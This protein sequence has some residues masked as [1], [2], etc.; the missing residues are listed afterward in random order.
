MDTAR[1]GRLREHILQDS[2]TACFIE[3]ETILD[4]IAHETEKLPIPLKYIHT[5]ESLLEGLSVPIDEDDFFAGRML[6]ALPPR[7]DMP[8][9]EFS[10]G[11]ITLPMAKI[12]NIGL[13]GI[14]Q[15]IEANAAARG[16]EESRHFAACTARAV[17]AVSAYSRRY[18]D[19]AR[20]AG[21]YQ[22]AEA[23]LRVPAG[24]AYDLFSALQSIWMTHFIFS[25]V[26]GSRDFAPGRIDT[27]LEPFC[28][29]EREEMLELFAHF[30]LKFNEITGT[31]TYDYKV[32]PI[33]CRATKQYITL[34][35]EFGTA[36]ELMIEAASL[37][38]L[39]Q[40]TF[41]F[42][43]DKDFSL[44]GKAAHLLESQC[45]F[46]N[47]GLICSKLI[48]SGFD[49]QTAAD[50][51][52]TGCNRVDL[53]G[54]LYNKMY[55]I[56][57]FHN[58]ALWFRE[59]LFKS[60]CADEILPNLYMI[61]RE[62]MLRDIRENRINANSD[63][64]CFHL[65]SIGIDS[66]VAKCR[67]LQRGG[68]DDIPWI[69]FMFSGIA[70]MA[71]SLTAMR[72]LEKEVPYQEILQILEDDFAGHED[73]RQRLRNTFPK[74]GNG[75]ERADRAAAETGNI[76][77]DA[78]ESA[79]AETGILPMASFYSLTRHQEFGSMLGATPDGRKAGETISENQ[80]PVYGM[81]FDGPTALLKSVS[82]LPLERT[83][84]GGL[85]LKFAARP[86]PETLAGILQTYF[87]MNGQHLGFTFI[88]R[89]TLE[90][91]VKTPDKYRNLCVR[92]TGYSEYFRN[93][94]T[95][96]QQEVIARTE[97]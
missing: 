76:L 58:P 92:I 95:A 28:V 73:L 75:D 5:L 96:A 81:D 37:L 38:Q 64:M 8:I 41:N 78:F 40:P 77:L 4:R 83:V 61:A 62:Y 11:H 69:H 36:A 20:A 70:T 67:D 22:L 23:C 89:A 21:K 74:F 35:P 12:V 44:A 13:E 90:D 54:K 48:R 47:Y 16:D 14:L 50:H 84:S 91:A 26:I 24:P 39:P 15:E 59:A 93:L 60:A 32:K 17:K 7:A 42:R 52:F 68:S 55:L 3:R 6:E 18:G 30:L 1:I 2:N 49:R 94:S 71:D 66:C 25:A 19:A 65:E 46:F 79:A 80:S 97:Y 31:A 43:L 72:E 33:P 88:N 10:Q 86:A 82:A 53:P 27:V 34:G 57:V 9:R 45:N 87:A 51:S 85:N 56:D 63:E 29:G